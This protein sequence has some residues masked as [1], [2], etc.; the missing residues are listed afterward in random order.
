MTDIA[1]PWVVTSYRPRDQAFQRSCSLRGEGQGEMVPFAQEN[2]T[3]EPAAPGQHRRRWFFAGVVCALLA[4]F[5]SPFAYGLWHVGTGAPRPSSAG[6]N[7]VGVQGRVRAGIAKDVRLHLYSG[8]TFQLAEQRGHV[9]ILNFWASW[10][11]PCREE[12]PVLERGWQHYRDR[13]VVMVGVDTWDT[14]QDARTFLKTFSIDYPNG[15]DASGTSA[16]DYGLTG[17]PE[18]FFIRPDGTMARHWIGPISDQ[19]FAA[20]VEELLS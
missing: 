20:V 12:A 13:G 7:A 14:E 15:P 6:V 16:I 8:G 9:V 17:L 5:L 11:P 2:P 18:T 3:P 10:C 1:L 19:Q 4:L